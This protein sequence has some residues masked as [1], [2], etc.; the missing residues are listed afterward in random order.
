MTT[1]GLREHLHDIG[2]DI[3]DDLYGEY[4]GDTRPPRTRRPAPEKTINLTSYDGRHEWT[5]NAIRG[6]SNPVAVTKAGG[7]K[8]HSA[9]VARYYGE[10]EIVN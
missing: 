2:L 8:G 10:L 7:W 4:E 9:M 5:R 1:R 6:G 3:A